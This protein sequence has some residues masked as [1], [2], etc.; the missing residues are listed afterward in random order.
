M[1]VLNRF[2]VSAECPS[3]GA[4]LDFSEGSNAVRCGY[5]RSNLLITGR[6]QVLS[7]YVSPR[8][9]VHRA[10]AKVAADA[11]DPDCR[12]THPQLHFIPYYNLIGHEVRWEERKERPP[13]GTFLGEDDRL[14]HMDYDGS[15]QRDLAVHAFDLLKAAGDFVGRFLRKEEDEE[16]GGTPAGAVKEEG[17]QPT[18]APPSCPVP[19]ADRPFLKS[20]L[21]LC[22]RHVS[23]S[24][25]ALDAAAPWTYSLGVRPGAVRLKLFR[26]EDL[27]SLG[28][29][30]SPQG[31][32]RRET[33]FAFAG[34]GN[35][36]VLYRAFLG[37]ILSLI[38]FPYWV[39][40]CETAG[41]HS[42][43]I[44]DALSESVVRRGLPVSLRRTLAGASEGDH[45]VLGFRQLMC[46][47][48]GW[49]L[50]VRP[51]DVIFSCGSCRKVWQIRRE[52]LSEVSYRIVR[53]DGGGPPAGVRY[54]PFW[55]VAVRRDSGEETRLLVPA[56]RYRSLRTLADLALRTTQGEVVYE[57]PDMVSGEFAGCYY[58]EDDAV[59]FGRF[60]HAALTAKDL[61]DIESA[62]REMPAAGGAFL[63]WVPFDIQ[64]VNLVEQRTR[65]CLLS[66]LL[67]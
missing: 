10:V 58:D 66:D 46:P 4:P 30:V 32:V 34:E 62:H 17:P 22:E 54:L 8:L 29:I 5:C 3:C 37:E 43:V 53:R 45:P 2:T 16:A 13:A 11:E 64:G 67:R 14:A 39:V 38:Y 21:K 28:R 51:D 49:D 36:R 47:N 35:A 31:P 19:F 41:Q 63:V 27:E 25:L 52:D 6:R 1:P 9:D 24:F 23:R 59:C 44:V 56:F 48:C 18:A 40:E 57:D 15:A 42:L 61:A 26:R 20:M 12:I 65:T 7:Y 55:S 33:A 50:P 60:V